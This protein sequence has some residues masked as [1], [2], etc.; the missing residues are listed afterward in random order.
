MMMP[1]ARAQGDD[2]FTVFLAIAREEW[3]SEMCFFP[4]NG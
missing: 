4:I 3:I 1:D 2:V